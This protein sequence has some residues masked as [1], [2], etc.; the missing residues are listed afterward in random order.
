MREG[1]AADGEENGSEK[2]ASWQLEFHGDGSQRTEAREYAER[3]AVSNRGKPRVADAS[4]TPATR[5]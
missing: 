3:I 2:Q 4:R 1:G 5:S